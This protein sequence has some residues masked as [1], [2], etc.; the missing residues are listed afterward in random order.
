ALSTVVGGVV[1]LCPVWAPEATKAFR[2]VYV[3]LW[4]K[5]PPPS[6][7]GDQVPPAVIGP[8]EGVPGGWHLGT[9]STVPI[10]AYWLAFDFSGLRAVKLLLE[11]NGSEST[12]HLPGAGSSL[13][14]RL[15]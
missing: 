5:P 2:K 9:D 6:A 1:E 8:G 12:I 15:L 11:D 10:K 13:A 3:S 7:D 14:T 4:S